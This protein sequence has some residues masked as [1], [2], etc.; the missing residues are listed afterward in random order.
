MQRVLFQVSFLLPDDAQ[1]LVE[2]EVA[3]RAAQQVLGMKYPEIT[4]ASEALTVERGG[5]LADLV[6]EIGKLHDKV[7]KPPKEP[8]QKDEQADGA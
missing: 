1:A 3:R 4:V 5:T 6:T 8:W 2:A 7:S